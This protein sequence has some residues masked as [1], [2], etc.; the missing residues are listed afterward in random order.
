MPFSSSTIL[1]ILVNG[2]GVIARLLPGYF[3]DRF[4]QLNTLAPLT[5]CFAI[6]AWS[7]LAVRTTTGLYVFVCVYGFAAALCQCLL[8][9]T[10][11]SLTDDLSKIGT[12]LGMIFACMGVSAL[13]GPPIG[14]A[15]IAAD[16]GSYVPA[17]V[18]AAGAC[19]IGAIVNTFVRMTRAKWKWKVKV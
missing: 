14:G 7:W 12:R 17:Q 15:L 11:A 3:A 4:G 6:V 19:T 5:Y 16:G 1:L 9:P 2:V 10:V 13:T 8:P 18:W